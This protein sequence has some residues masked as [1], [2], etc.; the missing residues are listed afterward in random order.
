MEEKEVDARTEVELELDAA[1][2]LGVS[3]VG[4]FRSDKSTLFM[5]E[6]GWAAALSAYLGG[7]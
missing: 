4:I 5:S 1:W 3:H 2:G 7:E 6:P